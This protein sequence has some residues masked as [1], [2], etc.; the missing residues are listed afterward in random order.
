TRRVRAAPSVP[1]GSAV[2]VMASMLSQARS[3]EPGQRGQV[4]A[5][6][7]L[8]AARG[9]GEE[10]RLRP[11]GH[12]LDAPPAAATGDLGLPVRVVA[13]DPDDAE[14]VAVG[15]PG[16]GRHVMDRRLR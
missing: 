6:G 8:E 4:E 3:G 2:A 7:A 10:F 12:E 5:P 16:G 15:Q 11:A 13:L 1:G 9:A 14:R